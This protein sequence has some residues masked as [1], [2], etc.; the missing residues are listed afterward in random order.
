M[1]L[2]V[3]IKDCKRWFDSW[4]LL[5]EHY[6]FNVQDKYDDY[7]CFADIKF[8]SCFHRWIRDHSFSTFAKRTCAYQGVRNISSSKTFSNVPN[9]WSLISKVINRQNFVTKLRRKALNKHTICSYSETEVRF[10][11]SFLNLELK[12][13]YLYWKKDN[14][15]ICSIWGI[16]R[17]FLFHGEIIF[18]SWDIQF[19]IFKTITSASKVN[20]VANY[21]VIKPCISEISANIKNQTKY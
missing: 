5:S 15:W 8:R 4:P 10:D 12:N 1:G 2:I 16:M 21:L 9:E 7:E 6:R 11:V 18:R 17:A 19:F 14:F 13:G 20:E 3:F